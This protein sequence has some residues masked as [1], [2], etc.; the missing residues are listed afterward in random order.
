MDDLNAATLDD[1]TAFFRTYYAPNNAVLSM[2]GSFKTE[3]ALALIKKYFEN[4][5]AQPAPAPTDASEPEPKA[6]R[7]K[8]LEDGFAQTP[9]LD[10]VSQDSAGQYAGLVRVG[11][12][13]ADSFQR[14]VVAVVSKIRQ[15]KRDGVECLRRRGGKTRAIAVLV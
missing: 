5:P 15:G 6:E 14:R 2:V 1:A 10:I 9:R 11:I 12:A 3:T 4:I 7:R 13:R 8:T